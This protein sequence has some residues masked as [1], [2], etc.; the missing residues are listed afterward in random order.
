MQNL[1]SNPLD[2]TF[3]VPPHKRFFGRAFVF[4]QTGEYG[5]ITEKNCQGKGGNE[6]VR[7]EQ[8]LLQ[9]TIECDARHRKFLGGG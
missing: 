6:G 8:T 9:A 3:A 5:K 2:E 7:Q 1:L 4:F